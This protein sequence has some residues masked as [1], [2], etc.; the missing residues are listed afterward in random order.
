MLVKGRA[1]SG[2]YVVF[3]F[4]LSQV[5]QMFLAWFHLYSIAC[6]NMFLAIFPLV[7][8]WPLS[9]RQ[10]SKGDGFLWNLCQE[11]P[12]QKSGT[13]VAAPAEPKRLLWTPSRV[14]MGIPSLPGAAAAGRQSEAGVMPAS[15]RGRAK[16]ECL[17]NHLPSLAFKLL[18]KHNALPRKACL[19]LT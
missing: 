15:L 1:R 4:L 16:M 12:G 10:P 13:H 6:L 7:T 2:P 19:L 18:T 5:D 3:L 11:C 14:S 9:T 8:S 17:R